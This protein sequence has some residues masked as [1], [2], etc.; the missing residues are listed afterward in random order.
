M[1][2]FILKIHSL[3]IPALRIQLPQSTDE[4]EKED[5]NK[6]LNSNPISVGMKYAVIKIT[7]VSSIKLLERSRIQAW[8]TS[9]GIR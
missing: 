3:L 5:F 2:L 4:A 6:M 9:S 7:H 1:S 8:R